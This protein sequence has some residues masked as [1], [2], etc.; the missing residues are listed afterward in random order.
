M[1]YGMNHLSLAVRLALT[2]GIF[3]A[4]GVV[5]AQDATTTT[6]SPQADQ[7]ATPPSKTKAKTLEGLVVT[8]SLIRRVDAE[9]ANPVV[10]IDRAAI[11]NSGKPVLGDVLQQMPAISGNATN[12]ANNSNGGGVASPLLEAG[13]GASRVSLRGLG[14]NRT[15]V[16]VNGQRMANA[17]VNLIPPDMIERI[18]VLAE[19]ASTV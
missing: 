14:I 19:G 6:N 4:A 5:Q 2:A 13:G 15:L 18:D 12:P 8:G 9:T 11:S 17:D 7:T 16:L 3:T 10:R 1:K